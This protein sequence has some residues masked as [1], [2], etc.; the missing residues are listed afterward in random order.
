AA[1]SIGLPYGITIPDAALVVPAGNK[2]VEPLVVNDAGQLV[3]TF[4]NPLP[5]DVNQGVLDLRFTVDEIKESGVR[6]LVWKVDGA[7]TTHRVIVTE[8]SESPQATTT[9]SNKTVGAASIPHTVVDGTVVIDESALDVVLPYT[10]TVASK[11]A[12]EVTIADTL[13]AH[14]TFV[15]GSLSGSKVVRDA[16]D[17][18]PVTTA[19][20]GLPSISGA[21]FTHFFSAEANSTYTFTYQARIADAA[22]LAA[23]RDELQA[24]YDRVDKVNGGSYTVALT[25]QVDVNGQQHSARTEVRG[26]VKGAD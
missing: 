6:D 12:R 4:K 5:S 2:A 21:S 9:W 8:P 26:S 20:S 25:N 16:D 15:P 14:L 17:L 3:V 10:V 22:A 1:V 13:G 18:N 11:A 23:L 24:A 7:P 19:L